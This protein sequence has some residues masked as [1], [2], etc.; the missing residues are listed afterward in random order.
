[1]FGSGMSDGNQHDP[2]DLPVV[3]AG[4]KKS[5]IPAGKQFILSDQTQ[6]HCNL[7]L[8]ILTRMGLSDSTFGE[9]T[10]PLF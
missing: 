1:M 2:D 10:K 6:P 7:Y 3:L 5:G 4:G 9:S 8:A